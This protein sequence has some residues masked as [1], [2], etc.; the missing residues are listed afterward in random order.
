MDGRSLPAPGGGAL[1]LGGRALTSGIR[2]AG[3]VARAGSPRARRILVGVVALALALSGG[4]LWV[5]DSS[6]VR[7]E[8]VTITG[9]AGGEAPR[10]SA[11]LRTA[12]EGMT[13]LHVRRGALLAAVAAYPTV[14]GVRVQTDFP[15][16]LRLEVLRRP[17]VAAL[18]ADGHRIAI[19]AD[20]TL[21]RDASAP[22]SAPTLAVR[23]IPPGRRVAGGGAGAV[24][25][26]IAAAP[27]AIRTHVSRVW[28][29]PHG[30]EADLRGGPAVYLGPVQRLHAKW[31]AA[32]RVVSDPDATGARYIDVRVPE[33]AV[34]GGLPTAPTQ[35]S[36]SP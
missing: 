9:T 14:A 23:A 22:A 19:A 28:V 4:Y 18:S 11:A 1:A 20:G 30:L 29:G 17:A 8:H 25:S 35:P 31:I 24:L 32:D 10:V 16:G 36:A 2:S 34:A 3:R 15:H 6:L 5:R 13:T 33:R 26:A 21:L 7:V 27:A 12:A